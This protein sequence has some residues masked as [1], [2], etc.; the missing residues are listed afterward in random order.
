[1][2]FSASY[3]QKIFE[4]WLKQ[5]IS[6]ARASDHFLTKIQVWLF[7][8]Q[9]RKSSK[10]LKLAF[11]PTLTTSFRSKSN[12]NFLF[13]NILVSPSQKSTLLLKKMVSV[14]EATFPPTS[15]HSILWGGTQIGPFS[16]KCD[17]IA[18]MRR[19]SIPAIWDVIWGQTNLFLIRD[20]FPNT[21]S[22][23]D[24]LSKNNIFSSFWLSQ[25]VYVK[26]SVRK[27]SHKWEIWKFFFS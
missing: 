23:K 14:K 9:L 19:I 10:V 6:S 13:E 22:R 18:S 17:Y 3:G 16:H 25:K 26:S 7:S 12:S 21:L 24:R 1:M 27:D 15:I 5:K 8:K 4:F 20:R 11:V 2:L